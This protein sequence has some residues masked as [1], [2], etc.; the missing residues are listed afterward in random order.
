MD[1]SDN[2]TLATYWRDCGYRIRRLCWGWRHRLFDHCRDWRGFCPGL[3]GNIAGWTVAD[4]RHPA[5]SHDQD[6]D[7]RDD[8]PGAVHHSTPRGWSTAL[9]AEERPSRFLLVLTSGVP[10]RIM[11]LDGAIVAYT[12]AL[13]TPL[14]NVP[15]EVTFGVFTLA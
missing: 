1:W 7:W 12:A 3:T 15:I 6:A 8:L 2:A 4:P 5:E 14:S 10:F 13:R 11:A 9:A